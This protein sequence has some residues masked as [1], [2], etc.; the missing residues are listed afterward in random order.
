MKSN[1]RN[2]YRKLYQLIHERELFVC[3]LLNK[4]FFGHCLE[5]RLTTAFYRKTKS[6]SRC[7]ISIDKNKYHAKKILYEFK[8]WFWRGLYSCGCFA[9]SIYSSKIK[10]NSSV[11]SAWQR[12]LQNRLIISLSRICQKY[13]GSFTC[14]L[15]S[16][17]GLWGKNK[18]DQKA[19]TEFWL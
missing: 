7:R 19:M 10:V 11:I 4:Y 18:I 16:I 13:V 2:N 9:S 5:G 15:T 6:A 8:V 12:A 17:A 3:A 1:W 14:N